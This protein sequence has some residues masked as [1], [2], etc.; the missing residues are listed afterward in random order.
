MFSFLL[1]THTCE[2]HKKHRKNPST[3]YCFRGKYTWK[4]E[5][6]RGSDIVLIEK[7]SEV[8]GTQK[9]ENINATKHVLVVVVVALSSFSLILNHAIFIIPF[10]NHRRYANM[11]KESRM[12]GKNNH[13][14]PLSLPCC[15]LQ[16][17]ASFKDSNLKNP[18]EIYSS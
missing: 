4:G 3:L 10:A 12:E 8:E 18:L 5:R 17:E 7:S 6:E 1:Q 13:H 9:V 15:L 11:K 2:T 14:Y 16:P